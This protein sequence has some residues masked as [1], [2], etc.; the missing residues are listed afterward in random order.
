LKDVAE[1]DK[2]ME[3]YKT[4]IVDKGFTDYNVFYKKVLEKD[5]AYRDKQLEKQT[6]EVDPYDLSLLFKE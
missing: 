6:K 5:I 2:Q 1:I 3:K 4:E